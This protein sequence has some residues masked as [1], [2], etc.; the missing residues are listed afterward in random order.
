MAA[1]VSSP[2]LQG[3][4]LTRVL[5]TKTQ[6]C[7]DQPSRVIVTRRSVSDLRV[8]FEKPT[9]TDRDVVWVVGY[10]PTEITGGNTFRAFSHE[11]FSL[12]RPL[13]HATSLVA[14]LLFSRL[15]G[16]YRLAEVEIPE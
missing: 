14:R 15:E 7:D 2:D 4:L 13:D 10:E 16:E 3:C 12:D 5:E 11:A 8:V 9:L 1:P 6:L